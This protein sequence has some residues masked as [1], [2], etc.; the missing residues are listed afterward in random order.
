MIPLRVKQAL[1]LVAIFGVISLAAHSHAEVGSAAAPPAHFS[2]NR[3]P[4]AVVVSY[5]EIWGELAEQD[6]V[7]LIRVFGD[8]RILVHHPVYTHQAG[9]YEM[10]LQPTE[11][12]DLLSSL[13]AKGLATFEPSVVNDRK[14]TQQ[15]ARLNTALAAKKPTVVYTVADATISVFELNLTA[16]SAGELRRKISWPGLRSDADRYPDVEPIQQLRAAELQLRG[17]L[18]RNDLSKVN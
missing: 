15:Q 4:G 18:D 5:R 11:L 16:V 13:L 12:E 7:P 1:G 9:D 3:D 6:P 17:L 10:W 14:Q 2:W 8:G